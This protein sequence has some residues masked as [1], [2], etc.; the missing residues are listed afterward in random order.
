MVRNLIGICFLLICSLTI[1]AGC[2]EKETKES[3]SADSE[4]KTNKETST[5]SEKGSFEDISHS[6]IT[7]WDSAELKAQG[8]KS[9][10][11]SDNPGLDYYHLTEV[12]N[13]TIAFGGNYGY[14]FYNRDKDAY[15]PDILQLAHEDPVHVSG[16]S[17]YYLDKETKDL[18]KLNMKTAEKTKLLTLESA[19]GIEKKDE[20]LYI[21][22]NNKSIAYDETTQKKIWETQ[23]NGD[24]GIFVEMVLTEDKIVYFGLDALAA[25]DRETG[26][27]LWLEEGFYSGISVKDNTVYA[28]KE[29]ENT[30]ASMDESA[31]DIFALEDG[32]IENQKKI[33]TTP[34]LTKIDNQFT[35][36]I[37]KDH[38]ILYGNNSILS[39]NLSEEKWAWYLTAGGDLHQTN[40]E[41]FN[42]PNEIHAKMIGDQLYITNRV[43]DKTFISVVDP[44]TGK[45]F[46]KYH[47]EHEVVGPFK[48]GEEYFIYVPSTNEIMMLN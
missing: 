41:Q 15:L 21:Y 47:L 17:M 34:K 45:E 10:E 39:Y 5:T 35:S 27:Q 7:D 12:S 37:Y 13:G 26:E 44:L 25:F 48:D 43:N 8:F 9:Q 31:I 2:S 22:S 28:M 19:G 20:S 42:N 38:L 16:D 40:D 23:I 30:I 33:A 36:D 1:L 14:K 11:L 6:E 29:T 32:N 3:A 46:N 4:M 24:I 18:Y